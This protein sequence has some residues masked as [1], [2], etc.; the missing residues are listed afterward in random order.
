MVEDIKLQ[1]SLFQHYRNS[2]F[3]ITQSAWFFW[4]CDIGANRP[5]CNSPSRQRGEQARYHSH[6]AI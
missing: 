6:R 5:A 4:H 3:T 1:I 2:Y